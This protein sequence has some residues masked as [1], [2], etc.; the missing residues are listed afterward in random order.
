[1]SR[2]CLKALVCVTFV[3]F[4]VITSGCA[5]PHAG[6]VKPAPDAMLKDLKSLD[7]L[8]ALFNKDKDA[9]RLILL[10]SPT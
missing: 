7:E 3:F 5:Q 8:R 9:P 10:L 2:T 4:I 1:M 6:S